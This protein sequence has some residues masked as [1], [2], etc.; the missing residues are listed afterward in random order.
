MQLLAIAIARWV[1]PAPIPP[2]RTTL[3]CWVMKPPLARSLTRVWLIVAGTIG[4]QRMTASVG[5]RQDVGGWGELTLPSQDVEHDIGGMRAM[6]ERFSSGGLNGQQSVGQHRVEDFDHLAIAMI[7]VGELAPYTLHR[8]QHAAKVV[9]WPTGSAAGQYT[10]LSHRHGGLRRRTSPE[11]A[12]SLPGHDARLM[13]AKYIRPDGKEQKNDFDYADATSRGPTMK[14]VA[15]SLRTRNNW[16]CK[17]CIVASGARAAGSLS[18]GIINQIR[19]F[20]PS[21]ERPRFELDNI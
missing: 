8:D 1:L 7:G 16:I 12:N 10:A 20:I 13:P 18:T 2:T 19:D 11:P 4:D 9:M 14:L 5:Q 21:D 15:T 3:R 6:T 17:R